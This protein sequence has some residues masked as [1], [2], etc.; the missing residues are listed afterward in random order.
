MASALTAGQIAEAAHRLTDARANGRLLPGLGD[1]T[2]T[3]PADAEAISDLHADELGSEVAGW[4]IGCTSERAM[5]MIGSPGPFAG[6]VFDGTVFEAGDVPAAGYQQPLVESE[7]A[8]ILGQDIPARLEP[9]SVDEVRDATLAVAPAFEIIDTRLDD[10]TGVGYLSLVADSGANGGVVLGTPRGT[11]ELPLLAGVRVSL[12][13]DG[14]EQVVGGG[15]DVLG[16]PWNAL[17]WLADHLGSRE[18]DLTAG[19]IVMSGTCT[20]AV[21]IGPGQEVTAHFAGLGP[22]SF[23]LV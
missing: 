6:R 2:P 23:T 18:I 1:C 8:F 11:D 17:S 15:A 20:G 5:E 14:E 7:F 21:A 9:W 12:D 22:I 13:I 3:S 16:D 10:F 4:K 19:Q